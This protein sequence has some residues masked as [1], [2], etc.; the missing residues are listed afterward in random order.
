MIS[1]PSTE[2]LVEA[3]EAVHDPHVPVSLR[4]MGMLR[5]VEIDRT[6]AVRV[7]VCVPC[8]AC[9][10]AGMIRDG[11]QSALMKVKGVREV[12]VDL[13]WHLPWSTDMVEPEVKDLMRANGIQI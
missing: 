8:M 11:I 13:G 6:G 2:E 3:L 4:R 12:E 9:P 7:A 10:G 5:E 1:L